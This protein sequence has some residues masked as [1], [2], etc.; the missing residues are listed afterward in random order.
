MKGDE[1]RA[2]EYR[3][4]NVG[5]AEDFVAECMTLEGFLAMF[6]AL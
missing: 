2:M 3:L 1:R 6:E 5:D 4:E